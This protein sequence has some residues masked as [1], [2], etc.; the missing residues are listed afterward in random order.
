MKKTFLLSLLIITFFVLPKHVYS[1]SIKS[2]SNGDVSVG[3]ILSQPNLRIFDVK[4]NVFFS[5]VP[6]PATPLYGYSGVF[7]ETYNISSAEVPIMYPQWTNT[8]WIGNSVQ[9]MYR[10]YSERFYANGVWLT[11][12]SRRKSNFRDVNNSLDRL[13]KLK[14]LIYDLQVE[15][16]EEMT[17]QWKQNVIN[18]GKNQ[19]GF[20]AQDMEKD[21]P[22]LV[23]LDSASNRYSVNYIGLI[24][25]I[26]K[27]IQELNLILET[28]IKVLEEEIE[29]LKGNCCNQSQ[30]QFENQEHNNNIAPTNDGANNTS[31]LF[32]NN[33]NPFNTET[34]IKYY[35]APSTNQASMYIYDMNGKQIDR[36]E[37]REKGENFLQ[38][39]KGKLAAG[40]YYYTLIADGK[41]IA[42]KKMIL[43]D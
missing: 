17:N 26:V 27:S 13:L 18:S 7:F 21:F 30:S 2:Y 5:Q 4:G 37:L 28:K 36:F 12:D 15:T 43:T 14:P 33:P 8:Y 40:I 19:I 25:E 42:T 9:Q 6:D 10:V 34:K 29:S 39:Q 35:L 20:I 38:I 24:P 23:E 16:R 3:R 11:S 41:E 32:Q 31:V 1:Q 22:F